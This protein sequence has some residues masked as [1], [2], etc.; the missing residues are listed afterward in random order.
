MKNS[1]F[2]VGAWLTTTALVLSNL[3]A[4]LAHA[5][6]ETN[7]DTNLR[8]QAGT[9]V[10]N[11]IL[12]DAFA[13]ATE[14]VE[15]F[16]TTANPVDISSWT[17]ANRSGVLFTFPASTTIA[18]NG[19][20]LAPISD[21]LT[22]DTDQV[23][24]KDAANAVMDQV[25]YGFA[26]T[27]DIG[28]AG[29]D[30]TLARRTDGGAWYGQLSPTPNATNGG[31]LAL[32]PPTGVLVL[33]GTS[34]ATHVINAA[35]AGS[36]MLQASV[37]ATSSSNDFILFDLID[38]DSSIASAIATAPLGAGTVTSPSIDTETAQP[39]VDG[40]IVTR[41]FAFSNTGIETRYSYGTTA[42]R[43]TVTPTAPL[44]AAIA[45]TATNPANTV[46][47]NNQANVAVDVT[48]P[49]TGNASETVMVTLNDSTTSATGT[50]ASVT[51]GGTATVT[52]INATG[53]AQGNLTLTAKISDPAGNVSPVSSGVL[54][55]KD[56]N[57]PAVAL[58][59]NG[60]ATVTASSS[61]TLTLNASDIGGTVTDMRIA[62]VSDFSGASFE[63]FAATKSWALLAGEGTRT[64]FVQVR[65]SNGNLSSTTQASILVETAAQ[66]IELVSVNAGTQTVRRLPFEATVTAGAA[67]QLTF[68]T[69]AT[70]PGTGL[71]AG[72][73]GIGRFFELGS[74][75]ASKLNFPVVVKIYYTLADLAAA[76]ITSE[77]QLQGITFFDT[78]SQ[79]WKFYS[80][81]GVSTADI[82]VDGN[83]YAGFLYA[84][85]D[86][87]TPMTALAD[88]TAPNA[89]TNLTATAG[90]G[91]VALSW[92][93]V[94]DAASYVVR[95]RVNGS[96]T[97]Y[98]TVTLSNTT[99][100]TTIANLT[101]GTTYEFGVAAV[102]ASGN[103]SV[104]AAQ[105]AAPV[106]PAAVEPERQL[107]VFA[108]R[109]GKGNAAGTTKGSDSTPP[110]PTPTPTTP[111]SDG[112]GIPDDQ[113]DDTQGGTASGEERDLS[114]LLVTLAILIIAIG[115]G[116]AGYYGYQWL[117]TRS[118]TPPTPAAKPTSPTVTPGAG[119]QPTPQAPPA[120]PVTPTPVA[121]VATPPPV[122]PP[123]PAPAPVEPAKPPAAAPGATQ[124]PPAA[125]PPSDQAGAPQPSDQ[126]PPEP[127]PEEPS[128][129]GRW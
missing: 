48:V 108:P 76:G 38:Q 122:T 13:E 36:V 73:T 22:D 56:T 82:T 124:V 84:N 54:V 67:T 33:A 61:V 104:F 46:N 62:N 42:L 127:K 10:L 37:G 21:A 128:K 68:A 111:D 7:T 114:R 52:G 19:F 66:N 88:T 15:L 16:N 12:S 27:D 90:N 129:E 28:P 81:T 115:A 40:P 83:A 103:V 18:A 80:S 57:A 23:T 58:Q 74:T 87:L 59:V 99:L 96:G 77:T 97:S 3:V 91:Q 120:Q 112:D 107:T 110:A 8:I 1:L 49:A 116:T 50:A 45:A 34:N 126:K 86:H 121:P 79:T 53:L 113:D 125:T 4:P 32:Q 95:Y 20:A 117:A 26:A 92:T 60:G 47:G 72:T 39:L 44:G 6:D 31:S 118:E 41:V 119:A 29:T 51:G 85:A 106:A 75:D 70:N 94:A 5:A 14:Y 55:T 43:D 69:Y 78:T 101:N 9:V 71:P 65:D 100:T 64:V 2:R 25:S 24:L 30:L 89:P 98:T 17:V 123:T 93:S 35:S 11:E 102:D 63:S 105:T 109:D